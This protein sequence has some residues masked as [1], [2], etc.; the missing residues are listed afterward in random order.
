M[1]VE[2]AALVWALSALCV[3]IQSYHKIDSYL[4]KKLQEPNVHEVA[5]PLSAFTETPGTQPP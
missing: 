5:L 4:A 1:H 3:N 2:Q